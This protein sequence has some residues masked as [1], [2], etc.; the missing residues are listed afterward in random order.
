[1][2]YGGAWWRN[3]PP[4]FLHPHHAARTSRHQRRATARRSAPC[5]SPGSSPATAPSTH[6]PARPWGGGCAAAA[7]VVVL[8]AVR[9]SLLASGSKFVWWSIYLNVNNVIISVICCSISVRQQNV[10]QQRQ[11]NHFIIE[12]RTTYFEV[13]LIFIPLCLNCSYCTPLHQSDDKTT[14]IIHN[15]NK[16][17]ILFA[18]GK[19]ETY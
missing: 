12:R 5:A 19:E 7:C 16:Y 3:P 4:N 14:N 13:L 2:V 8:V 10:C 17:Y 18:T 15:N 11:V 6:P 1:M 9:R